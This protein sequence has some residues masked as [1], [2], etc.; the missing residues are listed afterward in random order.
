M[1]LKLCPPRETTCPALA[2]TGRT[3]VATSLGTRPTD[4]RSLRGFE[5]QHG[6]CQGADS[7]LTHLVSAAQQRPIGNGCRAS[8]RLCLEAFV[9]AG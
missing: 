4:A 1:P 7:L 3:S 9:L 8:E 2:F 6:S 5:A